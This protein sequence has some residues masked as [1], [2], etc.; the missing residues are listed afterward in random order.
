METSEELKSQSS[1]K[2]SKKQSKFNKLQEQ[3]DEAVREK[4]KQ[5]QA[6]LKKK[7]VEEDLFDWYLPDLKDPEY[8]KQQEAEGKTKLEFIGAVDISYSK[9][10]SQKA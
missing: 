8:N 2:S 7:L 10:D 4:W 6:E 5:E 1:A 9:T 3:V